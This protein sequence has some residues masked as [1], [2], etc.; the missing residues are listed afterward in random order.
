MDKTQPD[1]AAQW[2]LLSTFYGQN[3]CSSGVSGYEKIHG[4][5]VKK[6][7]KKFIVQVHSHLQVEKSETCLSFHFLQTKFEA[8]RMI[9]F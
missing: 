9:G 5:L 6:K 4:H 7:K 3:D 1:F 8:L 2:I